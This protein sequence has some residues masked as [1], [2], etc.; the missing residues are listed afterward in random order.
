[1]NA[2][3]KL[4]QGPQMEI[5]QG[6]K[7]ASLGEY[8]YQSAKPLDLNLPSVEVGSKF[9]VLG[10][11]SDTGVRR[12]LGRGGA[13]AGSVA[14]KKAL[15]RLPLHRDIT[16]YDAGTIIVEDDDLETAQIALAEAVVKLRALA[17]FPIVLGGGHETAWGHY[18]GLYQSLNHAV[19]IL[20]FD[21]HF[22]LRELSK[23]NYGTSGTPFSQI[24]T[25]CHH[26]KQRFDYSCIGIQPYGNTKTLFA[27]AKALK[28]PYLLAEDI[29]RQGE[30]VV[31]EFVNKLLARV[32]E[33][34]LTICLDVLSV[35]YAPGVSATQPLGLEPWHILES[36]RRLAESGKL[37][38]LDIVEYAPN[39]DID[40]RT[41]KLAAM[42][43]SDFLHYVCLEKKA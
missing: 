21:A 43:V 28:V 32:N 24:A 12:N 34:Y 23:D 36:L 15:A 27:R 31:L 5:W 38:S 39:Y 9:A 10:F 20:N 3:A 40:E 4:Y 16:L 25:L 29:H 42:F 7:D 18:Q 8:F 6:R 13:V 19:P 14:I 1:M 35:A 17:V 26:Q 11:A 2:F 41:A 22:D 33:L 30:K 37:I